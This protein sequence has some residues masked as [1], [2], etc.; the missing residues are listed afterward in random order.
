MAIFR[1]LLRI[2][3]V[4]GASVSLQ[5]T[6]LKVLAG[7]PEGRASLF[8]LTRFV[9]ILMSSGPDWSNRTKLL[10]ARVPELNIFGDS[11]V[12]RDDE[13]WQI[14]DTGRA[15]LHLLENPIQQGSVSEQRKDADCLVQV[16]QPALRLVVDNSRRDCMPDQDADWTSST[17]HERSETIAI[18]SA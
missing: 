2:K 5:I 9:S 16:K 12:V 3:F 4:P 17:V 11:F 7:H 14:T 6:I 1:H 18:A 10:A 15:F 13:G 8:E